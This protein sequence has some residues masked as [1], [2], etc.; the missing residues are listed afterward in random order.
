MLT[1][2]RSVAIVAAKHI[3][4]LQAH[5]REQDAELNGLRAT[6]AALD[7][8]IISLRETVRFLNGAVREL[9]AKL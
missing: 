9:E 8:E 2:E 3:D 6:L 4:E 7:V 5:I 1:K